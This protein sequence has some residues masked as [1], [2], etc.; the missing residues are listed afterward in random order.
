MRLDTIE[1][2]WYNIHMATSTPVWYFVHTLRLDNKFV[3][4]F[5]HPEGRIYY[6]AK[7]LGNEGKVLDGEFVTY[8]TPTDDLKDVFG[9][10]LTLSFENCI[11]EIDVITARKMWKFLVKCGY[12]SLPVASTW[13]DD[14]LDV[15]L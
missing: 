2:F 12:N 6:C 8:I 1:P 13:G 3:E 14:L 9:C 4:F 10:K 11:Y 7:I 5:L 15:K